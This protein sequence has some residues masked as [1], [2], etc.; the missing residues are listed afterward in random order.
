MF[1]PY[2]KVKHDYVSI[3]CQMQIFF[4]LLAAVILK[5]SPSVDSVN[6]LGS[7]LMLIC[8]I[9][10]L[11]IG[12]LES[13]VGK[14]ICD[15]E[16]RAQLSGNI[17]KVW[18][19]I[20]TKLEVTYAKAS[21]GYYKVGITSEEKK[22]VGAEKKKRPSLT[23]SCCGA[24]VHCCERL[25]SCIRPCLLRCLVGPQIVPS[26]THSPPPSAP[27]IKGCGALDGARVRVAAA[28]CHADDQIPSRPPS[29]PSSESPPA[30]PSDIQWRRSAHAPVDA[31]LAWT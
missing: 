9:P 3:L 4:A 5:S 25:R 23:A 10:P 13:P 22:A 12:T 2:V 14:Y 29:A 7:I 28:T 16:K 19:K 17:D 24:I 1:S 8:G 6:T 11:G 30:S 31:R 20:S 27:S 26:Q 15:D 18:A 21:G